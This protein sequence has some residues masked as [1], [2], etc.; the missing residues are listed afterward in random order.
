MS[1]ILPDGFKISYF[2]VNAGF[3]NVSRILDRHVKINIFGI[4]D[5]SILFKYQIP[6]YPMHIVLPDNF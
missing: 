3:Q 2:Y 5:A 1:D 4:S 6:K